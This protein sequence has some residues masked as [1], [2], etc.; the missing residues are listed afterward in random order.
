MSSYAPQLSFSKSKWT[1]CL[2][3]NIADVG[4][5]KRIHE[6]EWTTEGIPFVRARDIVSAA[7]NNKNLS[8]EIFISKE[9]YLQTDKKGSIKKGDVLITGVGTIGV[10]YLVKHDDLFYYKDGNVLKI[11]CN[12][13]V[14]ADFLYYYISSNIFQKHLKSIAAT[15]TVATFTINNA[16]S[17]P[18]KFPEIKEQ[19]K[20]AEF[21]TALDE[22]IRLESQK[23]IRFHELK[24]KL[25]VNVFSF[26]DY[27]E[28]GFFDVVQSLMDYR[29]KTPLKLGM[30]WSDVETPYLA[31]SALNVKDQGIDHS[32]EAHYGTKVLY[33]KWM[34]DKPLRPK[35]ILMTTEAP[36]GVVMQVPDDRPYILSQRVIALDVDPAQVDECFFAYLLRSPFVQKQIERLCSGGTAKGISQKH[37]RE[38]KVRYPKSIK[39]QQRIADLFCNIDSRISISAKKLESLEKL[40]KAFMQRMFV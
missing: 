31:L 38:L 11:R 12:E 25:L 9:T 36:A 18:I 37:L 10:P 35:Q 3:G 28:T 22:K 17:S 2:I 5:S 27:C 14:S 24:K 16:I 32:K 33:N 7:T 39:T 1:K 15:G 13:L 21:F 29:G 4:S 40:K 34:K 20:I 19:Q 26:E 8:P 6:S 23:L 30:S